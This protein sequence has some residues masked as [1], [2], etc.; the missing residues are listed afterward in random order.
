M[1]SFRKENLLLK[2]LVLEIVSCHHEPL[3]W[4]SRRETA[5]RL[6]RNRLESRKSSQRSRI[7]GEGMLEPPKELV[8]RMTLWTGEQLFD[9]VTPYIN[10]AIKG[11]REVLR[12]FESLP[13][14]PEVGN[15]G[16][17]TKYFEPGASVDKAGLGNLLFNEGLTW[18]ATGP[19][20]I[21]KFY[22]DIL[23]ELRGFEKWLQ[24]LG[25]TSDRKTPR[26]KSAYRQSQLIDTPEKQ[27]WRDPRVGSAI[28]DA[29]MQSESRYT[30]SLPSSY[31]VALEMFDNLKTD[32][33]AVV[34]GLAGSGAELPNKH[35]LASNLNKL[36][37]TLP[38]DFDLGVF[39][40]DHGSPTKHGDF[41]SAGGSY[42]VR[43]FIRE[44]I[45][46]DQVK[47][48]AREQS[49]S[50][51][52][53]A[54]YVR[55]NAE[56]AKRGLVLNGA[57]EVLPPPTEKMAKLA[58]ELA[59]VRYLYGK[60]GPNMSYL[61][62]E[63]EDMLARIRG[64]AK[65]ELTHA[66]QAFG[67]TLITL[68]RLASAVADLREIAKGSDLASPATYEN[69]DARRAAK[70]LLS[71]IMNASVSLKQV[72]YGGPPKKA[73]QPGLTTHSKAG[74][75]AQGQSYR[76]TDVE[77]H[78]FMHS[79]LQQVKT[80]HATHGDLKRAVQDVITNH[81]DWLRRS[82]ENTDPEIRSQDALEA[83]LRNFAKELYKAAQKELA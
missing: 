61:T 28:Y 5:S 6:S 16:I 20:G 9:G 60:A 33:A 44:Y 70:K 10:R 50:M 54:G 19:Q 65:H 52:D 67:S 83:K 66:M 26:H 80:E 35:V 63:I 72:P 25:A 59:F 75:A 45:H 38:H 76:L 30:K 40:V 37:S 15:E 62:A 68:A 21:D 29:F 41:S 11:C 27:S 49:D 77:H 51:K 48:I 42:R 39:M 2:K 47:R 58:G 53:Y 34:D 32:A 14:E 8:D 55:Q 56:R 46:P 36:I 81:W 69:P 82:F 18:A 31:P 64:T 43:T 57:G 22:T 73:R 24:Q 12:L 1:S 13:N 74:S 78:P 71:L 4:S 79:A 17:A 7:L 23:A 3:G